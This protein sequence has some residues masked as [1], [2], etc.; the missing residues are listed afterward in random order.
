MTT[1]RRRTPQEVF[2][3][4]ASFYATSAVHTEGSVLGRLAE[5]AGPGAGDTVLD[6]GTGAGHTAFAVAPFVSRV[7]ATDVTPEMLLEV[8]RLRRGY[9]LDNVQLGLADAHHLPFTDEA[10]DLVTCR[11]AAHHFLRIG[12]SLAELARVL[13]PGGRLVI[14]DRSVPDDDLV[15][16]TMNRLDE[17]HDGSHV[18]EYRPG[19]WVAML[20]AAGLQIQ[21]VEP[22]V[23]HLPL[24]SLTAGVAPAQVSEIHAMVAAL[25]DH[26]RAIMKV[27]GKAGQITLNHWYVMLVAVKPRV[28]AR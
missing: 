25:D 19:E 5:M 7:V 13:R 4:R 9:G 18:R 11:R 14:D 24:T 8:R 16:A 3:R 12:C 22:Y 20:E 10:F 1:G 21:E 27:E 23:R 15:D 6:V 26:Q 17:L 28:P 2:G